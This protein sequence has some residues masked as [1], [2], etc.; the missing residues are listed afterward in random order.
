MILAQLASRQTETQTTRRV[1]DLAH[2]TQKLD[3]EITISNGLLVDS[4]AP[5]AVS[6]ED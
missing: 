2:E 6:N 5:L 1:T 4:S 3:A